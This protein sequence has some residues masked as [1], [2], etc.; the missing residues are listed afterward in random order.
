MC[1]TT[2]GMFRQGG[3][4]TLEAGAAEAGV[5]GG[6]VAD[7]EMTIWTSDEPATGGFDV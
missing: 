6:G 2:S 7:R 1:I 3:L 4:R 5:A